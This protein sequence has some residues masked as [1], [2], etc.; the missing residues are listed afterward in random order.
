MSLSLC[1][2][3]YFRESKLTSLTL[4]IICL[5]GHT[6]ASVNHKCLV[7]KQSRKILEIFV[8]GYS[9]YFNPYVGVPSIRIRLH[10]FIKAFRCH[11]CKNDLS[12]EI[13]YFIVLYLICS[14]NRLCNDNVNITGKPS[15]NS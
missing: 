1:L 15:L 4:K 9:N 7:K 8:E 12:L 2:K 11:D 13:K 5:N 10:I 3:H 6:F 14:I